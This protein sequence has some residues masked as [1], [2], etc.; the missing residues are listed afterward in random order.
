MTNRASMAG[1]LSIISGVLG[2]FGAGYMLLMIYFMRAMF[3]DTVFRSTPGLTMAIMKYT[4][5]VYLAIGAGLVILGVLAIVGGAFALKRTHWGLALAGAVASAIAFYP[6][7]I[8]TVIV[9]AMAQ[10]EFEQTARIPPEQ[11]KTPA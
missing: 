7:G 11:A 2:F 3:S 10:P 1:I 4:T 6:T 9:M 5:V 8:A